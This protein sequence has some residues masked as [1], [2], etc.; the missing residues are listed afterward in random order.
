MSRVSG[1]RSRS[2]T[3][4]IHLLWC[5]PIAGPTEELLSRFSIKNPGVRTFANV[6]NVSEISKILSKNPEINAVYLNVS[7]ED[8]S[9]FFGQ[10]QPASDGNPIVF[11]TPIV[12]YVGLPIGT[13]TKSGLV[14]HVFFRPE[15]GV[16]DLPSLFG[17]EL[18]V[19]FARQI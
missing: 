18:A 2:K 6:Q 11:S 17:K 1:I 3:P 12:N 4:P 8:I 19:K 13:K 7:P 5:G 10:Y 15:Q 16:I 9:T 14:P